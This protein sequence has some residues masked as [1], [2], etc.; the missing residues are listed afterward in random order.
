MS[1][2]NVTATCS[3]CGCVLSDLSDEDAP[4]PRC[5]STAR[6]YEKTL[7]ASVTP[8]ASVTMEVDRGINA[9]RLTM[10]TFV[11]AVGIGVAISVGFAA[12]TDS[13]LDVLIGIASGVVSIALTDLFCRLVLRNHKRRHR[14]MAVMHWMTG[15]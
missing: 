3:H 6:K 15:Q 7:T 8:M 4:C 12:P 11:V 1:D 14:V 5:G 10:F 9:D 13:P 2:E